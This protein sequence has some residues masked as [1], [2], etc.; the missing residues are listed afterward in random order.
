M[1]GQRSWTPLDTETMAKMVGLG[2]QY[3]FCFLMPTLFLHTTYFGATRTPD[4]LGPL[5]P[6]ILEAT[7]QLLIVAI[8]VHHSRFDKGRSPSGLTAEVFAEWRTLWRKEPLAAAEE[9]LSGD[10]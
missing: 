8:T 7:H 6:A 9:T 1:K 2:H 4:R 10:D 3:L 5:L